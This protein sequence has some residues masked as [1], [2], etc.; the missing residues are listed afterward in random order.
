MPLE[1]LLPVQIGIVIARSKNWSENWPKL[2][3]A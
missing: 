3:A 1:A 2:I